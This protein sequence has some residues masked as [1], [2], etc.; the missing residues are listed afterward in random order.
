MAAAAARM[1]DQG[2][3]WCQLQLVWMRTS[4]LQGL[5]VAAG[6][7]TAAAAVA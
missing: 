7:V 5:T 1:W 4:D 3:T 2:Q 6:V